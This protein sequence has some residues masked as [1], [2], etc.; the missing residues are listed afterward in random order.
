M[1]KISEKYSRFQTAFDAF[2]APP[3]PPS[4]SANSV[5]NKEIVSDSST[6]SSMDITSSGG[7]DARSETSVEDGSVSMTEAN[8]QS[9]PTEEEKWKGE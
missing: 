9:L 3:P 5:S 7:S 6:G 1:V 8:V 2:V 4:N